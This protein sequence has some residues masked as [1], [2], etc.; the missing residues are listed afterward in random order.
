M[1]WCANVRLDAGVHLIGKPFWIEQAAL[2]I[3]EVL[4]GAYVATNANDGC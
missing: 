3:R 1:P 4:H 2:E